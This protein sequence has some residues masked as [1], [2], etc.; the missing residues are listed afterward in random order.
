MFII[1]IPWTAVITYSDRKNTKRKN[2]CSRAG[3]FS[4]FLNFDTMLIVCRPIRKFYK[5]IM[6]FYFKISLLTLNIR[7][8]AD[9]DRFQLFILFIG[10]PLIFL[11][12]LIGKI[13]VKSL[14][15]F[16]L[17]LNLF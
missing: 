15:V 10:V 9:F 12:F 16:F 7:N 5:L 13:I 14:N 11:W 2:D 3:T 1:L 6:I 17:Q 8:Q 4:W